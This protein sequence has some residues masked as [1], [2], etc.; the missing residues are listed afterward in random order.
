MNLKVLIQA[1]DSVDVEIN[2]AAQALHFLRNAPRIFFVGN[3]GSAAIASH[4]AADWMKNG[5]KATLFFGDAPL[6]TCISNDIGYDKSFLLPLSHHGQR[7]DLLVAISSSGES[8][9]ILRAADYAL[10]N[11]MKLITLT[12][13]KPDNSLRKRGFV[14]FYVPSE[15][16][17]IVE[18]AHHAILHSLLDEHM[19]VKTA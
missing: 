12:G 17:G 6:L 2:G 7:G 11:G 4:M 14:N 10:S 5:G 3:G 9:N 8:L 16:Y 1:L 13:F 19:K 18:V 15:R